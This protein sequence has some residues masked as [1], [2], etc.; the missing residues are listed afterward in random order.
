M[1]ETLSSWPV[2]ATGSLG[3]LVAGLGTGVGALPILFGVGRPKSGQAVLLAVAAGIMLGATI[4]SLILPAMEMLSRDGSELAAVSTVGAGILIGAFLIWQI[5]ALVPHEHFEKGPEG[6]VKLQLG[7]NWLFIIAITLHNFPEGVSV[8]VAFGTDEISN[9]ISIMTGIGLQNMPEGLAVAAALTSEG[10]SRRHAFLVALMTGLVEPLGGLLGAAAVSL[11]D[12]I[13]PWALAGSAG[14][15]LYVIS[16][17]VIP[18]THRE[19]REARATM[20]LVAGFV[21]M[22]VLDVTL[23]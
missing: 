16:G 5:N 3:S 7:R 10:F 17:E 8:G 21:I 1:L 18:E 15:M 9:G 22:M 4:F 12:A 14:A 13:L 23:G 19:G 20:S 2:L 6:A 11:G